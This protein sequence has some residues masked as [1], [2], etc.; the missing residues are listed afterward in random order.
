MTRR[1][2]LKLQVHRRPVAVL[3]MILACF[4]STAAGQAPG[5]DWSAVEKALGRRGLSQPTDVMRF[6]FP[7][8]DLQVAI[9]NVQLL[10]AFAL[11]GW[12]AFHAEGAATTMM[13]D[14][15]LT[16]AEVTPVLDRLRQDGVRITAVHNHLLG[17]TPRITYA[18]IH[19]HGDPAR[20]AETVH[21]A[22]ALTQ[23]PLGQPPAVMPVR[24]DLDTTAITKALGISGRAN[25][26]V[27]QVSVPRATTVREEGRIVPPAMGLS[28]AINFQPL[29]G[30]RAAITGDFV[31]VASEVDAVQRALRASGI[32]ITALH[33]H[34]TDEQPRLFF[35]HFW[36]VDDATTLARGL[37]SALDRMAVKRS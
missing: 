11:G 23:T 24:L 1:F 18:H 32:S 12:V 10:P 34:L 30:N 9:G 7:R 15:V 37:R 2:L 33:S 4:G 36:A 28:T 29:G 13:G 8:G 25:G 27:Y 6:G 16:E 20:L 3:V 21:A 35:M 31:M 17:E 5:R 14:L 19:G 26:G 22:L